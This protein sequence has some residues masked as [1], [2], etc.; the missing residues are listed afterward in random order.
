MARQALGVAGAA[1]GAYFGGP[2]GAQIGFAIGSAIGGAIDP[3]VIQG[4]SLGKVPVQTGRDGVPIPY[5]WGIIHTAGNIIQKNPIV[6]TEETVGGGKVSVLLSLVSGGLA[7]HPVK[8]SLGDES[9]HGPIADPLSMK[10]IEIV[11]LFD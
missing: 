3:E 5:G 6:E 8:K 11:A 7:Y 4:P 9:I 1:I 2:V 10:G